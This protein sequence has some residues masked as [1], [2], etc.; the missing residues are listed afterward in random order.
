MSEEN[1]K[2]LIPLIRRVHPNFLAQSIVN[3]QPMPKNLF[4]DLMKYGKSKE[5]LEREGYVPVSSLGLLW[6]K[7][8]EQ[9]AGQADPAKV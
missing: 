2:A 9:D 6:I 4:A 8:T 7:K 1:L 3:S 5:E